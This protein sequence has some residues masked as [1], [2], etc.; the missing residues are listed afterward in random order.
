MNNYFLKQEVDE[1]QN[2][3]SRALLGSTLLAIT[4]ELGEMEIILEEQIVW[5]IVKSCSCV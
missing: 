1:S 3:G 2:E 5:D 4:W